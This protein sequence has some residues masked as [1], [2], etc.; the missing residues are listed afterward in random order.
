MG[1]P[2][3]T[4]IWWKRHKET[5]QRIDHQGRD[6]LEWFTQRLR[7]Y[8]GST[9]PTALMSTHSATPK[10]AEIRFSKR[11]E[12]RFERFIWR[13]RLISILPVLMSLLGSVGCFILGTQEELSAFNKLITRQLQPESTTALIGKVV[14]GIDYYVIGIALLIFGYGVYEL[15]ISDIDTRF[16]N[17]TKKQCN[18]LRIETL[19]SLKQKLTNVIVVALIVSAFKTMISFTITSAQDLLLFCSC[20]FLLAFSGWLIGKNHQE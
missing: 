1:H 6:F 19:E 11:F 17:S 15:I 13:F 7:C 3:A 16:E 20:V 12:N 14:G 18:L 8:E 5:K 4:E 10:Q 2:P 9:I